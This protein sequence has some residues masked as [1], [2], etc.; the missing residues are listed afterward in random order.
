VLAGNVFPRPDFA[1]RWRLRMF[2]LMVRLQRHVALVPRREGFSLRGT[3]PM[4]FCQPS[5]MIEVKSATT[6]AKAVTHAASA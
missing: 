4:Q 2:E 5:P 6:P 3:E 1:L